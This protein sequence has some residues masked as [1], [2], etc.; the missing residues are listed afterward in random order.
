LVCNVGDVA[1]ITITYYLDAALRA[2]TLRRVGELSVNTIRSSTITQEGG[3]GLL[4]VTLPLAANQLVG[5]DENPIL[6]NPDFSKREL[7]RVLKT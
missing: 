3:I 2:E 4:H 1:E 7:M 5:C 6:R